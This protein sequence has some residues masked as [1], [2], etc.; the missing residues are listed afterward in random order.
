MW[1][2]VEGVLD[3]S[4]VSGKYIIKAYERFLEDLDRVGGDDFPWVFDLKVAAKYI[5][6]IETV[7][8]H[9]RGEWAGRPFILSDWQV[10]FIAQLFGW[11]HKDDPKLRRFTTAHFFVA[12][13]S[14]KSQLAAAII[15]AMAVLDDDGAG[16]FV[17]AATK[18]DQA[19]EVFDEIRR[20]VK[21]S[22]PL[23]K[24]FTAN[25]QEIHGPK[26]LVIKPLSSDANTLDGL[27]LNIGCV[28]EMHAMKDGELYRVLASSMGSRKSPLMLAI[29][30]A[31]FVLDGVATEFVKGGKKVLDGAVKNDSLL[32]LCYEIDKEEGDAWDDPE[33]WKK[34]NPGLGASI[35]MEYLVKQCENAKLYG[36]RTI[37]E[38]MVKH[39]NLFVGSQDIW[40][41]DELW[42]C[43]SNVSMPID[44]KT[45]K[46][47]A[48]LG[49]DLAATDDITALTVAVGDLESGIQIESHYFLPERAVQRRLE[50]DEAHVYAHIE[51]YD[52]VVV[53]KG[54][55]TDYNVIRRLLSGHYVMDGKVQYDPNNLSE[56]YN[57]KGIAYDR[58]NSLNLIRDLEGDGIMCDPFGQGYASMSFPS[59]FFEK[60]A[61]EGKLHHGGDEMLRWM[62]GNVFLKLDP[63]GNIK[64][65]KSKSGDKID[66]VVS[67]IMA[68]GEMLTFEEKEEA[69]DFEFFMSVVGL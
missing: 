12:R 45:E 52:N 29:S 47:D 1:D 50:K 43:D 20:C 38:F 68:I 58:W 63:S 65:D 48:Y 14:G 69:P 31:G 51:E 66:G 10:A 46:L 22:A 56:K 53:T 32:F 15:L 23:N 16:Q 30:T 25:R 34:A 54:N 27:S 67:A 5:T 64:V 7:C 60:L 42:M 49:L 57:I 4:V 21:K 9:T 39:C 35:S 2:Y 17:T 28:D 13:K 44:V 40:I 37:T 8:I 26:D 62:M 6:F 33:A 24:R 59:K 11:V 19:K 55:V 36:G 41:E 18:R 61:L 3:G